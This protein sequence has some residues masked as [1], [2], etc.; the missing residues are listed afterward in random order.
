MVMVNRAA[1]VDHCMEFLIQQ[2]L[3][4]VYIFCVIKN[5][6]NGYFFAA[7]TMAK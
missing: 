2:I 6:S 3:D 5:N 7:L 1:L 4:P